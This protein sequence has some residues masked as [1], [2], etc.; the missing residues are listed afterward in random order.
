[1]EFHDEGSALYVVLSR[2]GSVLAQSAADFPPAEWDIAAEVER[3]RALAAKLLGALPGAAPERARIGTDLARARLAYQTFDFPSLVWVVDSLGEAQRGFAGDPDAVKLMSVSYAWLGLWLDE[4]PS[5]SAKTFEARALALAALSGRTPGGATS[6]LSLALALCGRQSDALTVLQQSAPDSPE[7]AS[8]AE[9]LIR[10]DLQPIVA[11]AKNSRQWRWAL[12]LNAMKLGLPQVARPVLGDLARSAPADFPAMHFLSRFLDVSEKH[13]LMEAYAALP[14]RLLVQGDFLAGRRQGDEKP[15]PS[16][17][18]LDARAFVDGLRRGDV[19]NPAEEIPRTA[20]ERLLLDAAVDAELVRMHFVVVELS[21]ERSAR[22]LAAAARPLSEAHPWGFLIPLIREGLDKDPAA[23]DELNKG[24]AK[25]PVNY[26]GISA[27][28]RDFLDV[29]NFNFN[30]WLATRDAELDDLSHED[31]F[32]GDEPN[33]QVGLIRIAS[34]DPYDSSPYEWGDEAQ[35]DTGLRLLGDRPALLKKKF[36]FALKRRP[37]DLDAIA[38]LADRLLRLDPDDWGARRTK[39]AVLIVRGKPLDASANWGE[40][41][42]FQPSSLLAANAAAQM[43]WA[44]SVAGDHARARRIALAAAPA[45]SKSVLL[46]LAH[47]YEETRRYD[48]AEKIYVAVEARY[49][50]PWKQ[51]LLGKFYMRTGDPRGWGLVHA[52]IPKF[53]AHQQEGGIVLTDED[54]IELLDAFLMTEEWRNAADLLASVIAPRWHPNE[55]RYFLWMAITILNSEGGGYEDVKERMESSRKGMH[56]DDPLLPVYDAFLGSKTGDE[57]AEQLDFYP[58]NLSLGSYMLAQYFTH[59]RPEP[60]KVKKMLKQVV[61]LK[62]YDSPEYYLAL[63][64]LDRVP[65]YSERIWRQLFAQ[66]ADV[67]DLRGRA[68]RWWAAEISAKKNGPDQRTRR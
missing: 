14:R 50:K 45:Y 35:A 1:V 32:R 24:L 21:A 9:A 29:Y 13:S 4:L 65:I 8:L 52:Q 61:A 28:G 5:D 66:L 19:G 53:F 44:C 30:E 60:E 46:A 2:G 55:T 37:R 51:P 34:L 7:I 6:E 49:G 40:V 16:I 59:V 39:S 47:A 27:L 18:P 62:R 10:E 57:A 36:T 3:S 17:P 12:A 15:N 26:G 63:K 38:A 22:A 67:S 58:E 20:R 42:R 31:L 56:D 68:S 48:L 41:V 33:A 43:A 11:A 25:A 64:Q 23:A 54:H